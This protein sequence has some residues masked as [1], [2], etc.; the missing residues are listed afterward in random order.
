MQIEIL[1]TPRLTL[2]LVTPEVMDRIFDEHTP[3]EQMLFFGYERINELQEQERKYRGGL[4]TY[5]K[6]YAYFFLR[7]KDT[8]EHIGWCGYHTWYTDHRR[9]EIGY[10]LK[11]AFQNQGYMTEALQVI[12][13]YGFSQMNLHRVEAFVSPTNVPSLRL[14]QIFKFQKEGHLREHY[15]VDGENTDSLVFSLLKKEFRQ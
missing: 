2:Q 8:N 12:L 13:E 14:M 1:T 11:D 15:N 9:A 3:A 4:T 5:N 6:K 7:T 10:G